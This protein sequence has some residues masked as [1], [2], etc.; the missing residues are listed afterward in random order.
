MVDV[1]NIFE[2]PPRFGL[3]SQLE[4]CHCTNFVHRKMID[5]LA[6]ASHATDDAQDTAAS[7]VKGAERPR[8]LSSVELLSC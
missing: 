8:M 5:P 4:R 3:L 7:R 6:G 1:W 2:Q